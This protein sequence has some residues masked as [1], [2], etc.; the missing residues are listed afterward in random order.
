MIKPEILDETLKYEGK[1]FKVVQRRLKQEDGSIITRDVVLKN[2]CVMGLI[3]NEKGEIYLQ[4][5]YRSGIDDITTGFPAGIIEDDELPIDAL[6]R[7]V[8]EETGYKP[9]KT[10]MIGSGNVS[11]GFTNEVHSLGLCWVD[12]EDGKAEQNLDED[13]HITNGR[14]VNSNEFNP[15]ITSLS[16]QKLL[17]TF[18]DES[19]MESLVTANDYFIRRSDFMRG[20]PIE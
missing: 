7:E 6:E 16:G 12:T 11:E 4:D 19:F 3:I 10:V 13:E 20:F 15:R 14:W 17:E 2:P 5:E 18:Y 9:K 8:L 1:I